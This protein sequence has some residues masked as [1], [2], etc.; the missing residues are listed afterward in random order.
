MTTHGRLRAERMARERL[1]FPEP[2]LPAIPII[3][4]LFHGGE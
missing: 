1:D 3:L 2:E 4:T